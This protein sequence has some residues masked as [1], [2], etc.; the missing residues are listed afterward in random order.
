MQ[1]I[2]K[3]LWGIIKGTEQSLKYPNKLLEW[4]SIDDKAKA[5]ISLDLLDSEIHHV[6]L[7]KSSKEM[8]DN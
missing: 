7:E 5:T 4:K 3:N 1:L 8:W 6:D 2:N